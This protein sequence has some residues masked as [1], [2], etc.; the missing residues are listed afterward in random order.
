[1]ITYNA[2][3]F[4]MFGYLYHFPAGEHNPETDKVDIYEF[5]TDDYLG[6]IPQVKYT[7]NVVGNMNEYSL[8]IGETTFGGREEL[9]DPK[10]ILDYGSL[11]Y[12]SLQRCKTARDAIKFINESVNTY[13]YHSEGESF[14]IADPDEIWIMDLISK[15]PQEEGDPT[16]FVWVATRVPDGHISGHA[17]LP[18]TRKINWDDTEN[19]MYASDVYEFAKKKGYTTKSKEEFDFTEAYYPVTPASARQCDGRV[20]SFYHSVVDEATSKHWEDYI[21]GKDLSERLPFTLDMSQDCVVKKT[22]SLLDLQ[23]LIGNHYEGTS[24]FLENDLS[25]M[26]YH[27]LQRPRPLQWTAQYDGKERQFTHE[28]P[29]GC[30]QTMWNFVAVC[31]RE[32]ADGTTVGLNADDHRPVFTG[33]VFWFSC[34][35]STTSVQ[36][37]IFPCLTEVPPQL[38]RDKASLF[39]LNRDSLFWANSLVANWV[40]TNYRYMYPVLKEKQMEEREYFAAA[41]KQSAQ[42]L[43]VL[44]HV[45]A[46]VAISYANQ[47]AA[48]F[49]KKLVSDWTAFFG[50]LFKG[51]F[52]GMQHIPSDNPE[53]PTIKQLRNEQALYD[54]IV[55]ETGDHYL[56]LDHFSPE[57]IAYRSKRT[58]A[59]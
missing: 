23:S 40:Y 15:G 24:F 59:K 3:A 26:Y 51:Y 49:A 27:E 12:L 32:L 39:I 37:P 25:G 42:T 54:A 18:R 33:G 36:I 6:S 31:R 35:D 47:M 9:V 13:G 44:A 5:D 46:H 58:F 43:A 8:A 53:H 2:D 10:G 55:S 11:I 29:T 1:M 20:F 52:D 38:S 34:D 21:F 4:P 50:D 48:V 30:Q 7:Y 45:D 57:E 17:N 14:S 56:D 16:R 19:V 28:R 22:V 41:A